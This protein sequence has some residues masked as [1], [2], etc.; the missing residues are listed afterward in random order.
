MVG[1]RCGLIDKIFF[2]F[3]F[4]LI[5]I[6]F[7]IRSLFILSI[8]TSC[9]T[10]RLA[11]VLRNQETRN[12][13]TDSQR[14]PINNLNYATSN[15]YYFNLSSYASWLPSVSVEVAS[16][17][18]SFNLN[19]EINVFNGSNTNNVSNNL[20]ASTSTS[21]SNSN[22]TNSSNSNSNSN[23]TTSTSTVDAPT[24]DNLI[25]GQSSS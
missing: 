20:N 23:S 4:I 16:S 17:Q 1:A 7:E 8:D 13:T 9:P 15:R 10:C 24:T 14:D 6:F 22:S 18:A 5:R 2:F 11:L 12:H 3:Y 21:N 25:E 19:G